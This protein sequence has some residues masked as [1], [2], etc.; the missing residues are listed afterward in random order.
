MFERLWRENSGAA[1]AEMA[2]IAPLLVIL[3]FGSLELGHYF[4]SEHVVVEAVRDGAR[5]ASRQGFNKFTCPSDID[6]AIVA[7]TQN[8][9]RTD[10]VASGGDI[11]LSGWTDN[12]S[13]SV[14][15]RCDTSGDYGSFYDGLAGVPVVVV[16]ATV[17]YVS[18]L[19]AIG[20]DPTNL[21]MHAASEAPVMGV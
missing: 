3:M 21:S 19:P 16:S 8:V 17:P 2:L 10:Q 7:N 20:F 13:V 11:R 5:F 6:A 4:Y 18:L 15:M 12:A 14:T 9:T 1:A